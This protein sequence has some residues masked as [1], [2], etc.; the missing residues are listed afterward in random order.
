MFFKIYTMVSHIFLRKEEIYKP[1]SKV[2]P[3]YE[4][5]YDYDYAR[6]YALV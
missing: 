3:V 5:V 1:N 2:T 4:D 6:L